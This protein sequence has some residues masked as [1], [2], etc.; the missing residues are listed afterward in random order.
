MTRRDAAAVF[1]L[2]AVPQLVWLAF[3]PPPFESER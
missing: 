3:A 1:A 2:C